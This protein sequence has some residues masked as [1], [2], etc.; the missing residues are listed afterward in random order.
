MACIFYEIVKKKPLIIT[1]DD[2]SKKVF[3]D[4]VNKV[5][6]EMTA[7]L[8]NDFISKGDCGRFKHGFKSSNQRP[9]FE[10]YLESVD[11]EDFNDSGGGTKEEFICLLKKMMSIDPSKRP[12]ATECLEDDFFEVFKDYKDN[13]YKEFPPR[14]EEIK[15]VKIIPCLERAWAVNILIKIY[16]QRQD[17]KWYNDHII[18]HALR[19]YDDYLVYQYKNSK[20]R[21]KSAKG[22]GRLHTEHE[23]SL[24]V[25]SCVYMMYK[26]FSTLY[27]I[28]TW[29]KIFPRFL[30]VEKNVQT[31]E[32]FE[33]FYLK[34][35]CNYKLYGPTIIEYLD[36]NYKEKSGVMKDLDIMKYFINYGSIDVKY[37]GTMEDLYLQIREGFKN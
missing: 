25:Y 33:K 10:D 17:I 19:L 4:I 3:K 11:E 13:M 30:A 8:I 29:D 18:F 34:N 6:H 32:N 31:I 37:E 14:Q 28:Y 7:T 12:T 9:T 23:N 22:I 2:N 21:A 26:Y 27:R 1:K 36:M 24:R 35:I 20:L 5:P 15:T 16:N